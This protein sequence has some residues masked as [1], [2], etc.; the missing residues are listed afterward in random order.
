MSFPIPDRYGDTY[1]SGKDVNIDSDDTISESGENINNIVLRR[2]ESTYVLIK[3]HSVCRFIMS[4]ISPLPSSRSPFPPLLP[5]VLFMTPTANKVLN[6]IKADRGMSHS[7]EYRIISKLTVT[8]TSSFPRLIKIPKQFS[9]L[10][11]RQQA[12]LAIGKASNPVTT[13]GY[14]TKKCCISTQQLHNTW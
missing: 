13:V 6:E 14:E 7:Y 3:S 11:F 5:R 10:H 4:L 1:D 9:P 8:V 12:T 2:K